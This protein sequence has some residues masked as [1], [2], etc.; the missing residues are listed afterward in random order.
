MLKDLGMP[1]LSDFGTAVPGNVSRTHNAQPSFYT[2]P[3]VMLKAEWS[4]PVDI[5]GLGKQLYSMF[6]RLVFVLHQF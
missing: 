3:E 2:F 4:Y 6:L 1:F 5:W